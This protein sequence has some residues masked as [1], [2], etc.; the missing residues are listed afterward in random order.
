MSGASDD[1][2]IAKRLSAFFYEGKTDPNLTEPDLIG[3][4]VDYRNYGGDGSRGQVRGNLFTQLPWQLREWLT[5]QT[6]DPTP[7]RS[8]L[9]AIR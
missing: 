6:F 1:T 7:I 9:C 3:P 4:V 8:P 2:E 5:Q